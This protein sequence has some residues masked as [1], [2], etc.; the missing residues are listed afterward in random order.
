MIKKVDINGRVHVPMEMRAELGIG[1]GDEVNLTL[2]RGGNQIV[3]EKVTQQCAICGSK[4]NLQLVSDTILCKF[5]AQ[6]LKQEL[7]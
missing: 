7:C 4:K 3:I 2:L 6:K 5:C 1:I